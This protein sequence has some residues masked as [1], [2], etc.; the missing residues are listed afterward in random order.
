MQP[1][2]ETRIAIVDDHALVRA[3]LVYLFESYGGFRIVGQGASG[4]EALA[5][6]RHAAPDVLLLDLQMP[7]HSGMDVIA[8]L[9]SHAPQL[10]IVVLSGY[11]EERYATTLLRRGAKAYLNKACE[12]AEIVEAVRVVARG[13]CYIPPRIAELIAAELEAGTSAAGYACLTTRE[14][15]VLLRTARGQR[16][17]QAARELFLSPKTVSACRRRVM[18]KLGLRTAAAA[19]AYVLKHGLLE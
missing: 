4:P 10:G 5:L 9:R 14:L 6:A 18:E 17:T 3:S 8:A 16:V 19:T 1:S 7:G 13:R 2:R 11:P 15:Q 12:P